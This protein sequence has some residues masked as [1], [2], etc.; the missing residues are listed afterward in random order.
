MALMRRVALIPARGGSKRLPRKNILPFRG[1]PMIAYSIEAAVGSGLFDQV[2]ASTEDDEIAAIATAAG[3][4]V[5]RRDPALAGDQVRVTTVSIDFLDRERAHGRCYDVLCVLYATAPMRD[6]DDVRRTVGL[7]EPGRCS[8]A[9]AVT[10]YEQTPHQ[11]LKATPLP[12]IAGDPSRPEAVALSPM[13]PDIVALRT[14]SLPR[15]L[16]DNGSTYAVETEAFRRTRS[17][18][19]PVMRGHV[20]P[21]WRSIDIDTP[22][23]LDLAC[24]LADRYA[25]VQ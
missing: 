7:L 3:A 24:F 18:Y 21:R 14:D 6:A 1:K 11:A 13:W 19:D 25:K 15:L 4:E 23:N 16:V 20:M 10:E 22:E 12:I 9:L 2:V 5:D 17:F 8:F